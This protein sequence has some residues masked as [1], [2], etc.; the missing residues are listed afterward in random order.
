M[1]RSG[2]RKIPS[3]R[4]TVSLFSTEVNISVY[5]VSRSPQGISRAWRG[6]SDSD[7]DVQAVCGLMAAYF[8]TVNAYMN[9]PRLFDKSLEYVNG[10]PEIV[11]ISNVALDEYV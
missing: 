1:N 8:T 9:S 3:I 6:T 10:R 11:Q 2:S 5:I 4:I 7:Y